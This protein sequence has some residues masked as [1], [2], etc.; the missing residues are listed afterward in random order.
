[1]DGMQD[2]AAG[3]QPASAFNFTG[4][5]RE[6]LPIALTN[7][8]LMLVTLGIY[9]FWAKARERRYLWSRTHFID[10]DLEWTGTGLEMFLGF[11]LVA[12]ALLPILLFLQFGFQYLVMRGMAGL[13]ALLIVLLYVG[14]LYMIG[15]AQF[16]ALRYRLSRTWW[17]GI[18]GGAEAS[19]WGY[20]VQYL[21]KTVVGVLLAGFLVPWSMTSLWNDRWNEMSF[22]QQRFSANAGTDGLFGRWLLVYLVPVVGF[23]VGLVG[24]SAVSGDEIPGTGTVVTMALLFLA[25]YV[26]FLLVSLAYYAAFYRQ[27][28]EATSY[29]DLSFE[30]TARTSDWLKLILGN[31]ALVIVT[32]GFGLLFLGYRNWSFFIRHLEA[33]GEINL[34]SLLQSRTAA[35]G[36]AEGLA[37]AFDI[38]AI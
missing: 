3:G 23:V 30:F 10:D 32:L 24:A 17:H 37:D 12:V 7:F 5:W 15:V 6:F 4:T 34:D 28:V 25:F 8:L 26:G 22:G 9:R 33:R 36:D 1:M 35:T 2:A 14:I 20:G 38:G 16:R 13:A 19:G 27:V 31:I 29:G 18:R 11:L 21:W